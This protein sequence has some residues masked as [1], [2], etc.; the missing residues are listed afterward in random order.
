VS[1][2]K[3]KTLTLLQKLARIS[4]ADGNGYCQCVSCGKYDHWKNMDGGHYIA[5]GHSSYW[6]LRKENI[7]P[8]C[9]N[10]NGFGMKFGTAQIRYTLWMIDYYG[11]D[12]VEEMEAQKRNPVKIYKKDY[13]EMIKELD[14]EI[15]YHLD[16]IGE[17]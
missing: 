3:N 4:A 14:E 17:S 13:E 10:C 11:R 1:K 15:K 7:H 12:F 5:K 16:R 6:A 8:Q 2:L 9:K